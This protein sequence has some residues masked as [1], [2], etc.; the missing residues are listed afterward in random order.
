M[1]VL[2]IIFVTTTIPEMCISEKILLYAIEYVERRGILCKKCCYD[3]GVRVC[4]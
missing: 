3:V 2:I 4:V 1:Q